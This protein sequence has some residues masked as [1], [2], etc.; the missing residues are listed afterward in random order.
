MKIRLGTRKDSIAIKAIDSSIDSDPNRAALID[1]S[2]KERAIR[3]ALDDSK[4]IGYS[5]I[6]NS[7]FHR[8]TLEILM[9]DESRRR[10]GIGRALLR[11][12]QAELGDS[13]ELWTSTNESNKLMQSLLE[14]EGFERTGIVENLD[15]DDP[16]IIYFKTLEK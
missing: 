11:N 12:A 15:L 4:I 8:H 6:N 13:T 9:V 5:I 14:S 7:F 10:E 16:E 1:V 2:L 3:V